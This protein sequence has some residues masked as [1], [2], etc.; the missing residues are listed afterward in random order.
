MLKRI[1]KVHI[2]GLG[3]L[4]MLYG[5]IIDRN[6]GSGHVSF[7][8]DSDRY[9]HHK[10]DQYRINGTP[11]CFCKIKA[12]DASPCDLLILAV[13]YN[14]LD[15]ALETMK[16]SVDEDTLIISVMNGIS[17]EEIIGNRFGKGKVIPTVAQGMDAMH[18]GSEL[19]FSRP[20]CLHVG[21]TAPSMQ[22]PLDR[23]VEFFQR[24]GIPHVLEEDIMYR[25]WSK[26]MVNVGI[27]QTCMIYNTD[28][29]GVL[30]DGTVEYM[31]LIS[32]MREVI[33]L[34]NAEGIPVS[35]QELGDYLELMHSFN[36]KA[37]PSMGQDRINRRHSE[38]ELFAGT[39]IRMAKEHNIPVPAN[40]YI[41]RRVHEIESEY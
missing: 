24:S 41:Y 16:S 39:V 9:E 29:E 5:S 14:D 27:N 36:P 28:Y 13:K 6:L 7:I 20:G 18:F 34:A 30:T 3:A 10:E 31:T 12:A 35:E 33:L 32:A 11:V 4:G 2:I 40:Q 1:E 38:V 22:G 21:I 15:A 19:H 8:M 23:L 26:F 17:T 37:T 25:M